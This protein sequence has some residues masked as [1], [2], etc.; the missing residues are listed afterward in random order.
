MTD[1]LFSLFGLCALLGALSLIHYNPDGAERR[2]SRVLFAAA[3][4]LPL[5]DAAISL[6]S[7][8][9]PDAPDTEGGEYLEIAEAA[10]SDGIA[11]AVSEKFSLPRDSI[12]VESVRF[13]FKKMR[14]EKI[15]ITLFG[16]A[17]LADGRAIREFIEGEGLGEC[18]VKIRVG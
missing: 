4:V 5:F 9:L 1:Y 6:G 15:K 12:S 10:F 2:A 8:T 3:L 14:A 18:E 7:L 11:R 16:I 17:A 13:D